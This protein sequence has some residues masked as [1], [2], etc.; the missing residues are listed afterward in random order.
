MKK[1]LLRKIVLVLIILIPTLACA[2]EPADDKLIGKVRIKSNLKLDAQARKEIAAAAARIKKGKT[3]TVKLRGCYS[4]ASTGD[5]YLS[6]SVFMA[7]EVEQYMKT[8][9]PERQKIYTMFSPFSDEKKNGE[10]MVEIFL[11]PHELKP[12][13]FEGF[14]VNT[15]EGK[16]VVQQLSGTQAEPKAEP[17][18]HV[19]PSPGKAA[20]AKSVRS[21]TVRAEQPTEDARRAEELVRRVKERAAKR[22]KRKDDA[23]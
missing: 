11:Y 14:R 1:Y 10:N 8:L 6:K 3:G 5:E 18:A 12:A 15:V 4:A 7:R 9:L 16:P 22:A 2:E 17:K 13:D 21:G 23:E 20:D 19:E